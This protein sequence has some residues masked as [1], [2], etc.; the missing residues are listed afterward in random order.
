MLRDVIVVGGGPAGSQ[1]AC[2]LADV[3][4]DRF[5]VA[6]G[7]LVPDLELVETLHLRAGINFFDETILVFEGD[8][9]GIMIDRHNLGRYLNGI[10]PGYRL[11]S[12]GDDGHDREEKRGA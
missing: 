10:A 5:V 12:D 3:G 11:L 7:D 6:K 4:Y 2:R 8:Q 9:P 1:V